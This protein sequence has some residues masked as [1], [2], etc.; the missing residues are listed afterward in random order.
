[1][2]KALETRKIYARVSKGFL[3]LGL[4]Y[5]NTQEQMERVADA[6]KEALD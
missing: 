2:E 1:M 4:H 3:R 5:Y 6:L